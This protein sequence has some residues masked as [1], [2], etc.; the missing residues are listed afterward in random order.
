MHQHH[1]IDMTMTRRGILSPHPVVNNCDW[2]EQPFFPLWRS[3]QAF[4]AALHHQVPGNASSKPAPV[5]GMSGSQGLI[6]INFHN[7]NSMFERTSEDTKKTTIKLPHCSTILRLCVWSGGHPGL[8]S[9]FGMS[10]DFFGLWAN[11]LCLW[12]NVNCSWNFPY[13]FASLSNRL[14]ALHSQL[15]GATHINHPLCDTGTEHKQSHNCTVDLTGLRVF[16]VKPVVRVV[17]WPIV[18]AHVWK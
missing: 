10:W 1:C 4:T 14:P 12:A 18:L 8:D 3:H 2:T 16:I 11:T 9:G 13:C 15:D 7:Q 6:L 5:P 17:L